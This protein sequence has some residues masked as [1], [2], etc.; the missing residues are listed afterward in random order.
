MTKNK[1]RIAIVISHPIQ[2]FCPQ[3][4]SFTQNENIELKVF[5][6]SSL[7][8]KK[9]IDV[10]F[11]QEISWGNLNLDKFQ[12]VFLNG[13]VLL[14]PDKNIDAPSLNKNLNNY[15]PDVIFIYGYFQKL[16]RRAKRWAEKNKVRI[17]YISDSESRHQESLVKRYLKSIFLRYYFSKI[18]FFLTVGNANE[19]YYKSYG[20]PES[21]I[22]RMH[23]PIDFLEYSNSY[24]QKE[25]L[26]NSIRKQYNIPENETV[27]TV[28]GKL[29][30]WKNQDHIIDAMKLLETEGIYSTL[31]ILGSGEMKEKWEH[32][33][34]E[35]KRSKVYFPGF[36]NIEELPSYYSATDIYVHPSSLEPHSV[37]ISEAIMMGCPVILSNCCGSYGITDDVQQEKNGY[38]FEFGKAEV[39]AQKIRLLSEN[40]QKRKEFCNYSHKIAVQFQQ[41]SHY[42]VIEELL[43]RYKNHS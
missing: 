5:F 20:V 42:G 27:L 2:H 39:L 15:K 21:K 17:A 38:V 12:H 13:D 19:E 33:A 35:L 34:K 32:K 37:A 41:K 40:V 25:V 29:V 16:Q 11:N 3:Y 9:F 28:V 24:N 10:D 30:R 22:I 18:N 26:R 31:F 4:A 7:G 43:E 14:Q 6:A 23:Y 8:Y 1:L 36:V